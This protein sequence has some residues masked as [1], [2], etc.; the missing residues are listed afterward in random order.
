MCIYIYMYIY[1]CIYIY[2]YVYICIFIYTY[3]YT[4]TYKYMYIHLHIHIH[5]CIHTYIRTYIDIYIYIDRGSSVQVKNSFVRELSN[6]VEFEYVGPL[7]Q[8]WRPCGGRDDFSPSI[9]ISF[10]LG[11]TYL[12]TLGRQVPK[13]VPTYICIYIY[14]HICT[15]IYTYMHTYTIKSMPHHSFLITVFFPFAT[16]QSFSKHVKR[17]PR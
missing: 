4:Y 10:S 5:T 7:L 11:R 14:I 17:I 6:I 3:T 2:R 13:V 9:L 1:V 8:T 12:A 15:Y 16:S